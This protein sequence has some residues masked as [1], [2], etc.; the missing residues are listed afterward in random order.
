[1]KGRALVLIS[2]AL[3][4]LLAAI[5][6]TGVN[7]AVPQIARHLHVP[8][9]LAQWVPNA[10]TLAMVSLLILAGKIG[11][12][13]GHRRLY[14][15][16]LV[17]FGLG[18]LGCGVSA[19]LTQLAALRFF[20]GIGSAIL[21]TC[22]WALIAHLWEDREKAFAVTAAFF[23]LGVVIGPPVAGWLA[24]ISL[25]GFAGWHLVFLI[26]IPVVL[27]A[28]AVAA[29]FTPSIQRDETARASILSAGLLMFGLMSL[30]QALSHPGQYAAWA[31][32]AALLLALLFS[33]RS[34]KAKLLE[35]ALFQSRTF[36]AA[37]A[38][39]MLIMVVVTGFSF[40][41]TFFMQDTL[42]YSSLSTGL[43]MLPVPAMMVIFAGIGSQV[44]QWRRGAIASGILAVVALGYLLINGG[45]GSYWT[46]F[47][48]AFCLL[49]AGGGLLMTSVVSAVM[50]SAP[51]AK[52]GTASGL[53]NTF[54]QIGA[55][56]GVAAVAG[57]IGNF[58]LASGLLTAAALGALAAALLMEPRHLV[59]TSS[60]TES[61][62]AVE[63]G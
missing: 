52:A 37:N 36:T 42:K 60:E 14:L 34:V 15:W 27:V 48:I 4:D 61:V 30:V 35:T 22:G 18:S 29:V 6:V 24:G 19:S 49:G 55:L 31:G 46:G 10:Y 45:R 9:S 51:S 50:G 8:P 2:I 21:Y 41:A 12:R 38:V 23:S 53:L 62:T 56:V 44:R 16:G 54:Q 5:D 11:D 17:V 59:M 47:F 20:Q 28:L 13:Y 3:A 43:R 40:V 57:I 7:V 58:R 32:A 63:E 26:N 33:E 25:G 39:S 1:V